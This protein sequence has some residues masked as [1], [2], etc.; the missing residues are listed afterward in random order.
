MRQP[1]R[2][3][4]RGE[5][6]VSLEL[7]LI[8]GMSGSGK[9][10]A[11]RA[12]EDAGYFCVDNLP[13]ELLREFVRFGCIPLRRIRPG[14]AASVHYGGTFPMTHSDKDL[15]VEPS[16]RLR[17]AR[18][19]YLVDGSVFPYLPAKGLTFTMMA[20]ANR[21]GTHLCHILK[22]PCCELSSAS[23]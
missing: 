21:I 9:S 22:D 16:C 14:Y 23:A 19:V 1:P 5:A 12:L 20:N 8:T 17:G 3:P 10:V 18:S 2:P 15:T 6:S 11:L 7:I 13:P 4:Q